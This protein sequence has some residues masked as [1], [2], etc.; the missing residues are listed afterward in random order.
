MGDAGRTVRRGRRRRVA[1]IR[2]ESVELNSTEATMLLGLFRFTQGRLAEATDALESAFASCRSDPW[3]LPLVT[4]HSINVAENIAAQ[5]AALA[6]RLYR[7][8]EEPFAV[9]PAESDRRKALALIVVD[10]DRYGGDSDYSRKAIGALSLR[11]R[12]SGTFC[13]CAA[14]A[15]ADSPVQTPAA[16]DG[17]VAAKLNFR[18][19]STTAWRGK[20]ERRRAAADRRR[21]RA[22]CAEAAGDSALR[23]ASRVLPCHR[24]RAIFSRCGH[25]GGDCEN[26]LDHL[27]EC[28]HA[29]AVA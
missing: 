3:P 14:I 8:L 10:I 17:F 2:R 21:G 24:L 4:K 5:D 1:E 11:F 19:L 26:A 28:P 13:R 16:G 22:D 7:A 15:T 9:H 20:I 27:P 25:R 18:L 6:P 23:G 12:G 29:G